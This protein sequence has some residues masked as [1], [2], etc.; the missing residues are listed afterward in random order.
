M[1]LTDQT[2]WR[3]FAAAS[4]KLTEAGVVRQMKSLTNWNAGS[5]SV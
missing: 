4:H 5:E 1:S 2:L 3:V